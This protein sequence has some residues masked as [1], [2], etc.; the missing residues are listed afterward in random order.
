MA[1]KETPVTQFARAHTEEMVMILVDIARSGEKDAARA[2]AAIA[3]L[4]RGWGTPAQSM[5]IS[6]PK[7]KEFD[8]SSL[9]PEELK[10]YHHLQLKIQQAQGAEYVEE[11]E[12]VP[13]KEDIKQA[14]VHVSIP[15]PQEMEFPDEPAADEP[16]ADEPAADEP[17][18]DEPAADEPA[19]DEPAAET[20][21]PQG[22][23]PRS[24]D[25]NPPV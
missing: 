6:A 12:I 18:A 4:N 16:A 7:E 13:E 23:A 8:L 22:E 2:S 9:T 14:I 20:P 17:A 19:A 1:P 21:G 15:R 24:P 10:D 25:E 3:I 11:G 5:E